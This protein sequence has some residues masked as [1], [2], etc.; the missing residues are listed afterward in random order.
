MRYGGIFYFHKVESTVE[1]RVSNALNKVAL[2]VNFK[3]QSQSCT[4]QTMNPM[5]CIFVLFLSWCE[6]TMKYVMM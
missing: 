3:T 6:I 4:I 1:S 2:R 5:D